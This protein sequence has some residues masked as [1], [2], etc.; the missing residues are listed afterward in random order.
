VGVKRSPVLP[1]FEQDRLVGSKT[2]WNTSNCSQPASC[3]EISQRAFIACAS[4]APLPGA[5]RNVTTSRTAMA[6]PPAQSASTSIMDPPAAASSAPRKP[7]KLPRVAFRVV[8]EDA[9]VVLRRCRLMG[10]AH[11]CGVRTSAP[12]FLWNPF[13][14]N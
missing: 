13:R 10:C 2:L 6:F 12:V 11:E 14:E 3:R 9:L 4:S 8:P 1:Q 7:K 5:A